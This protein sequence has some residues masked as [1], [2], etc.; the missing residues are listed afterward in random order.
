MTK[1]YTH[2]E[3]FT[4]MCIIEEL[5]D[6]SLGDAE[7]PWVAFREAHGIAVLR[8][9][10]IDRLVRP[11]DTAWER[12]LELDLLAWK[13]Y[14]IARERWNG[15]PDPKTSPPDMP[16]D[17]GSFDYEFLPTWLRIAVDWSDTTNGPRVKGSKK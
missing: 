7:I 8:D 11:A 4:A 14:E 16:I 6:T 12:A 17:Q 13:Q 5:I 10:V 3:M 1:T 9:A 2:G 15:L